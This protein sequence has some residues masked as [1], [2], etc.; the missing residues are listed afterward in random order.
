MRSNLGSSFLQNLTA[1]LGGGGSHPS[2]QAG[3]RGGAQKDAD[4]VWVEVR[5]PAFRAGSD[6][7]LTEALSQASAASEEVVLKS[8]LSSLKW[9]EGE[10][11]SACFTLS[12]GA[13]SSHL[14]LWTELTHQWLGPAPTCW[15]QRGSVCGCSW[16]TLYSPFNLPSFVPVSSCWWNSG[17]PANSCSSY[18]ST[19]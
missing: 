4:L 16:G 8:I 17:P 12:C 7:R 5:R 6:G 13:V 14:W 19:C 15:S 9:F 2:S 1:P 3:S 10:G 18:A 11:L